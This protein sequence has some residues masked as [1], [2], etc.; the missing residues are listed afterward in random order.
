MLCHDV[1]FCARCA[2]TWRAVSNRVV[3]LHAVTAQ[4]YAVYARARQ[5]VLASAG[6]HAA[7]LL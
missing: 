6:R 5:A 2:I 3:L 1:L 4:C 7:P